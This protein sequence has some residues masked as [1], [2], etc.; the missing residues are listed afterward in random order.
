MLEYL[1]NESDKTATENGAAAYRTSGSYCLD[2][3]ATAGALRNAREE[4]IV[5]RF[6][7]AFAEDSDTAMKLLFFA[8]DI[9]GGLGERRIFRILLRHLAKNG[10]ESLEKNLGYIAEYG[11]FDDLLEL[12]GTPCEA[13]AVSLLR[14]R[15]EED[16]RALAADGEVSLLGK[17]LPSVNASSVKTVRAAKKLARA[18]GISEAEYRRALTA[19]RARIRILENNLRERDYSFDYEKQPS[20]AMYKYRAAFLRNDRDRYTAYLNRVLNGEARLHTDTLYPYELVEGCLDSNFG[21]MRSMTREEKK[22]VNAAWQSL[23][24]FSC[25]ENTLAVVDTSGSMYCAGH[26]TPASVAL[27]LGL[28]CA[29][30]SSGIFAGHFIEFSRNARLIKIEGKDFTSRLQFLLGFN[31]VANTNLEA[32]FS[33]LLNTAVKYRVAAEE[34]P[35][36]LIVISDMEFDQCVHGADS[37]VFESVKNRFS[38]HGYALPQVVFWNVAS[39]HGHQPVRANEQGV[40]LVS[41]CSPR[42]FAEVLCGSL[43]P[44]SFMRS[45]TESERYEKITA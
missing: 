9:R 35:A 13:A 20:R 18:F 22:A 25:G 26:P 8:R 3:F 10:R 42:L 21:E 2:F 29:E 28:Y 23:P 5:L 24:D 31:E 44:Y 38:E 33:L 41:G 14:A 27:S 7:R 11:R 39:R 34:M 17:W 1:Q 19:L 37:T 4:D 32:V 30:H 12:L 40:A 45:V 36:R 6:T 15:F 43:D 16:R